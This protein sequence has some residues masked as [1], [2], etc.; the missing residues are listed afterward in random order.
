M[1]EAEIQ[2][3]QTMYV[4]I[5]CFLI[6]IVLSGEQRVVVHKETQLSCKV[7]NYSN[8]KDVKWWY[9]H[10]KSIIS[11][12][13]HITLSYKDRMS[14]EKPYP[15]EWN[16]HIKRASERDAGNYTSPA[17]ITE[18]QN[19]TFEE[20]D[21]GT[22]WCNTTGVPTPTV[23]WYWIPPNQ[24][25][26]NKEDSRAE[27]N[28]LLLYNMSRYY[29]NIYVC[30]ASNTVSYDRSEIRIR[31]TFGPEV[32]VFQNTIIATKGQEV[33]FHCAVEAF[34]MEGDLEWAFEN[35]SEPIRLDWKYDVQ[36]DRDLVN[37]F[38]TL[39]LSMTIRKTYLEDSDYGR[40][41]CRT[42]NFSKGYS[43][44]I[45]VLQRPQEDK[46]TTDVITDV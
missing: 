39:F 40:Y 45:V 10:P 4:F 19:M 24:A 22:L 6:G 16:L 43:E 13:A 28:R 11:M 34:P 7:E 14:V 41:V 27:G 23:R 36:H 5:A 20:G 8:D 3:I 15:G 25:D 2:L 37:D 26:R 12:D 32:A 33:T 29:D 31:V 1:R 30:L 21:T 17:K 46:E 38:N 44:N 9:N 35:K 18:T 42:I